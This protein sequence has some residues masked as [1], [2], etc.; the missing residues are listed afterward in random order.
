MKKRE[1]GIDIIKA[2]A[3]LFV[4]CVHF[5]LSCGYYQTP[6]ASK[7]MIVMTVMRWGFMTGVPLFIISTGYL[8]STAKISKKHYMSLVPIIITYFI[9]CTIRM[10]A[11]NIVYGKIH[12]LSSGIKSLL[13]YQSA[14]YVGM[15]IGL[16]LLCPFLNKLWE[17]CSESEH[18]ILL[19]TLICITMA[20]S[21]TYYV[22]PSYF[23]FIYPLTYYF[24][25]AY[26]RKYRPK[27]NDAILLL[28]AAISI[29]TIGVIT[30]FVSKGNVFNP[31]IFADIDNGQNS[32]F[33]ATA[34]TCLFLLFYDRNIKNGILNKIIEN[35]SKCSLEIYLLQ[36]A[37]NAVIY[38]YLGR[39]VTGGA[40]RYFWL[41]FVCVPLS[42]ILSFIAALLYKTVYGKVAGIIT[43]ALGKMKK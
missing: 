28:L 29:F 42:F 41:F 4:V 15:Y 27:F 5:Y 25:G 2:L 43:G 35:I 1:S 12:T 23:R 6:I 20:Y 26:I 14:W 22:F 32:L 9:L 39:I 24:I 17:A 38:T 10:V 16:M 30:V 37:F 19:A 11:E 21:V 33:I 8:K 3:V 36:A 34:A 18:K 40:E 7:K 13:T 31:G